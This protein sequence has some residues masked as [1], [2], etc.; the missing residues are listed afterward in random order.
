MN[1]GNGWGSWGGDAPP[2]RVFPSSLT[3]KKNASL[4][5]LVYIYI[6]PIRKYL[7][8]G[9]NSAARLGC[10]VLGALGGS[11]GLSQ[12]LMGSRCSRGLSQALVDIFGFSGNISEI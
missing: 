9:P 8:R 2:P 3:D 5:F 7:R 4:H 1:F 10:G 11:R 12:T 6:P